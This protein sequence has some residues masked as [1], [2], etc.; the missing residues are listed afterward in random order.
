MPIVGDNSS[1]FEDLPAAMMFR[2]NRLCNEFETRWRQDEPSAIEDMLNSVNA[3]L[4]MPLLH[5]LLPI[6]I[7]WRRRKGKEVTLDEYRQRFPEVGTA[8]LQGILQNAEGTSDDRVPEPGEFPEGLGDYSIV[9]RIG[10]GGMGT[11]YE[12]RHERMGRTVAIKVMRKDVAGH[13]QTTER[14]LREIRAA[15]SLSHRNIVTAYDSREENGVAFLVSEFVAGMTL[16]HLVQQRGP[17]PVVEAVHYILQA[18]EGLHYAH[19]HGIIHRDIK[20]QNLMIQLEDSSEASHTTSAVDKANTKPSDSAVL[21]ILDFGLARLRNTKA[22]ELTNSDMI[23]GTAAYMAPEQSLRPKE[24]DL[25]ADIYSLGCTFYFLLTA[26][27]VY[28]GDSAIATAFAHVNEPVPTLSTLQPLHRAAID[29]ILSR[30]LAKNPADRF[31]SMGEVIAALNGLAILQSNDL[32]RNLPIAGSRSH[33]ADRHRF[34]VVGGILTA[35]A[36]GIAALVLRDSVPGFQSKTVSRGISRPVATAAETPAVDHWALSFNETTSYV[37]LNLPAAATE[38]I[39]MEAIVTVTEPKMSVVCVWYNHYWHS[40]IGMSLDGRWT[41]GYCRNYGSVENPQYVTKYAYTDQS[42]TDQSAVIIRRV[43]LGVVFN[44]TQIRSFVDGRHCTLT[45]EAG[46]DPIALNSVIIGNNP[47]K[48]LVPDQ[49]YPERNFRGLIHAIRISR[50]IRFTD[51]FE[52]PDAFTASPGDD[53]IL[54]LDMEEGAGNLTQDVLHRATA[55]IFDAEWV[56]P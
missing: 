4:R 56:R 39:T 37:E 26:Q 14:F 24:V 13:P 10:E 18:A 15:A 6:E 35:V 38:P 25:R 5:E 33:A 31:Q 17:L 28:R 49:N 29:P 55:K 11:V 1:P 21:K 51:D 12:A 48:Y 34:H 50:G 47:P 7:D 46:H 36:I 2:I 3:S 23:I 40:G 16:S 19:E 54:V 22:S 41:A 45:V 43:H 42:A 30:M 8:C 27:V 32:P 20:P 9:R 52:P 44:G 53:S